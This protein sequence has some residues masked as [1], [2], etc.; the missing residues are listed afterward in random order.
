MFCSTL[1]LKDVLN[2]QI[3]SASAPPGRKFTDVTLVL[4]D[5]WPLPAH[6]VVLAVTR[7]FCVKIPNKKSHYHPLVYSMGILA[8][9]IQRTCSFANNFAPEASLHILLI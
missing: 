4:K 2:K 8:L 7:L 3:H 1:K 5:D 9:L 6:K